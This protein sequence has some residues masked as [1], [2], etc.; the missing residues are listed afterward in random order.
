MEGA[1]AVHG[2]PGS[3]R[4]EQEGGNLMEERFRDRKERDTATEILLA[5]QLP[6]SV[7]CSREGYLWRADGPEDGC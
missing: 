7:V 1:A 2:S 5:L 4:R 3:S 6:S